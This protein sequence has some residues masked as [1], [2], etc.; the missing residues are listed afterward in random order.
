MAFT[1][2]AEDAAPAQPTMLSDPISTS[3]ADTLREL[4]WTGQTERG[5]RML[6]HAQPVGAWLWFYMTSPLFDRVRTHPR[7]VRLSERAKPPGV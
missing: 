4:I 5:L 7:F 2:P 6:E 1:A 3:L